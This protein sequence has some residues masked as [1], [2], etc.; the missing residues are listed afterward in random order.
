MEKNARGSFRCLVTGA[1]GFVGSH[2]CEKLLALGHTV[3]GVDNFFSGRRENLDSFS[4]HPRFFFHERSIVEPDLLEELHAAHGPLDTV[5]HLAA[6]VSVPYSL[7]HPEETYDVN[8]RATVRLLD[9]AERL[10]VRSF[11]FAGSAAEYGTQDRMPLRE[12]DAGDGT[13]WLS[14]YGEAKYR[15]TMAVASRRSPLRGVSL[16][17]F[18]IYGPRQ[19]PSSPY[20]GVISRFVDM[21]VAGRPLTVFGD[22]LQTRDFVFV[23]DVVA[24]YCQAAGAADG[25]GS[26]PCGI[27]NVG[28]GRPTAVL[29]LARLICR[30]TER[31]ES[32]TF[33]PERPGDIRH[34]TASIQ[35]ALRELGWAP[36]IGLEE[37]LRRTIQWM[38]GAA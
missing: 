28:S 10:R 4:A 30:L 18:N 24:A 29:D 35:S 9:E 27:Y 6:I 2:L 34:S 8:Y 5:F 33:C 3:V 23:D 16:R 12:T 11:V 15:A 20:S 13:R 7:D 38:R 32:I 21:A 31:P 37:G 17:C 36:R 25:A 26:G 1:A 19:D 22:G 14:P